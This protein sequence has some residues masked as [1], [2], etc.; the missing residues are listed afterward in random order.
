MTRISINIKD[1]LL[2]EFDE[3][4]KEQKYTSRRKGLEDAIKEY[5]N[6]HM[7]YSRN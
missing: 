7:S 2:N 6:L 5:I 1:E 4:L 3:V